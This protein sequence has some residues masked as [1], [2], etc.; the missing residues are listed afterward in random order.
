MNSR[1]L[2]LTIIIACLSSAGSSDSYIIDGR[3]YTPGYGSFQYESTMDRET[4]LRREKKEAEREENIQESRRK[5]EEVRQAKKENTPDYVPPTPKTE[6]L[7]SVTSKGD[8]PRPNVNLPGTNYSTQPSQSSP[9]YPEPQKVEGMM[10]VPVGSAIYYYSDGQFNVLNN[11]DLI[12]VKAPVGAIVFS[13]PDSAEEYTENGVTFFEVN[14]ATYKR[15]FYMGKV[16]YEVVSSTG[17]LPDP[18]SS[19]E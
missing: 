5:A 2:I 19:A 16:V 4:R 9:S 15:V 3:R 1:H 13:I 17:G 14:N 12:E 8:V 10:M 7:I 18:Q 6:N 11:D